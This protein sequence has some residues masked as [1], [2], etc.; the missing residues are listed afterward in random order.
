[1]DKKRKLEDGIHSIENV[2]YHSS[3]GLSRSALMEF[4]RSPFHYWNRYLGDSNAVSEPSSAL[5]MGNLI[6]T[7][8]LE[9]QKF[10]DEFVIRPHLDRR[11]NAGKL[12]YNQF[13]STL[14][15]RQ[16][17]TNDEAELALAIQNS[18]SK[19][20]MARSLLDDCQIEQSI[21]FTH[22]ETGI[23]CKCRPDAWNG[24]IV[25]DLKT[26]KDASFRAFQN[27]AFKYGYFLQAGMIHQGLA[28]IGLSLE[29][30]VFIA[31]EKDFPHAVGL[32]ILDEEAIDYGVNQFNTLM[33]SFYQCHKYVNW[34]SYGLNVLTVPNYAN[35]EIETEYE[36]E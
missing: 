31:V 7:M 19:N 24:S 21:Y 32:F 35:F 2:E 25:V 9:P 1:M 23:Q 11:T 28:S 30:F 6:H 12:L 14:A 16:E 20:E 22:K 34:P 36:H 17:I 8:V 5:I 13:Q 4:K 15:G 10:H 33:T 18:V 26:T 29:K 3:L 27:S